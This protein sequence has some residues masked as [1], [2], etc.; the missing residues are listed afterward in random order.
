LAAKLLTRDE[1]RRIA[2]YIAKLLARALVSEPQWIIA[3][4]LGTGHSV[5]PDALIAAALARWIALYLR[6]ASR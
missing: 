3:V 6:A 5:V 4:V 1:A 2:A